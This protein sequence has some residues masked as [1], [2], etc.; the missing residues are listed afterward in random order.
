[1]ALELRWLEIPHEKYPLVTRMELQQRQTRSEGI[2]DEWEPVPIV[3]A[4]DDGRLNPSAPTELE[5]T[6]ASQHC[7]PEN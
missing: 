5:S 7:P 3:G 2:D 6:T 4:P 1:M